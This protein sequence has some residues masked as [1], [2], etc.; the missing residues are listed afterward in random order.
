MSAEAPPERPMTTGQL[1]EHLTGTLGI[2]ITQEALR[3]WRH[4][5][6]GP[7]WFKV[8]GRALYWPAKVREWL[9]ECE[10]RTP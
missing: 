2:R 3:V 10:R 4:R 1:A 5:K 7:E 8:G 6:S 9:T